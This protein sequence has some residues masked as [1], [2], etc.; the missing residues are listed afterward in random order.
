MAQR[1]LSFLNKTRRIK[2]NRQKK[3]KESA[4]K[5]VTL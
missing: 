1:S 2:Q 4:K 3:K 5:L